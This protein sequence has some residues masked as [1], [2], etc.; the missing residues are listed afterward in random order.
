MFKADYS[1]KK[2]SHEISLW[3]TFF[4]VG[5]KKKKRSLKHYHTWC[6][7]FF[8]MYKKRSERTYI[9]LVFIVGSKAGVWE[10][11][12]EETYNLFLTTA[13]VLKN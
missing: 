12:W 9:K 1:V 3:Y 11:E 8:N 2:I 10:E 7:L 4:F 13:W 5:E 6:T